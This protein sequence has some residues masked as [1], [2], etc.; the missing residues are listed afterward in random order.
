[1]RGN[2][3]S[4]A[5]KPTRACPRTKAAAI[6]PRSSCFPPFSAGLRQASDALLASR[7]RAGHW[8]V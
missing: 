4:V 7:L 3:C 8:V 5:Y 6:S 1:M 2:M